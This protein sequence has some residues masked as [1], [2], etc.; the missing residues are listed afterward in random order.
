MKP[1]DRAALGR[2]IIY[3]PTIDSTMNAAAQLD[4]GAVVAAD[5]QTAGQG[6]HGHSWHS[7][8]YAGIYCSIVMRPTPVL[9]LALG[10]AVA[11]AILTATSVACDL[12]WPNDLMLDGRKVAGVLVQLV[13]GKAVAGIGINVNHALLPAE[14]DATSLRLHAGREFAREPILAALLEAVDRFAALDT[15]SVLRLFT[16]ASSYARGRRVSVEQPGGTIAGTTAGLDASGFLIVRQDDGIETLI[17]AG[18]V[19]AES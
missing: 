12:R 9:T 7:E 15:D 19:R 11:D 6:R 5:E 1:L 2:D 13:N 3:Y 14:L 18:G 4:Y 8:A 16:R 17:L 10:L